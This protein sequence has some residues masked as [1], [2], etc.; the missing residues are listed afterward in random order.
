[1]REQ[2]IYLR[3]CSIEKEKWIQ[4]LNLES[5]MLI[6]CFLE[7]VFPQELE[8]TGFSFVRGRESDWIHSFSCIASLKLDISEQENNKIVQ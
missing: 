6:P 3:E 2:P 7:P 5:L 1:M 4:K 8:K